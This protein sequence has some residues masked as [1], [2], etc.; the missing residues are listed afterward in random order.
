M[1]AQRY[2]KCPWFNSDR[3]NEAEDLTPVGDPEHAVFLSACTLVGLHIKGVR[4]HQM[5]GIREDTEGR[6]MSCAITNELLIDTFARL[7]L[8]SNPRRHEEAEGA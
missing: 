4:D 7:P 6:P 8:H 5:L 2:F 1:G 3:W